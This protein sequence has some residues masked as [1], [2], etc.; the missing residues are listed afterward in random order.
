[1]VVQPPSITDIEG[2]N[3]DQLIRHLQSKFPGKLDEEDLEILKKEKI[4]G[5]AFL[6]QTKE[7]LMAD[8]MKRGPASIIAKYIKELKG[9]K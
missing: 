8:H 3:T 7:D 2:W 1:M 9:G 6:E 5:M 4:E